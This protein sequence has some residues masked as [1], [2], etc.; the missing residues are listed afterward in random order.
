MGH[1]Y[2]FFIQL[3]GFFVTVLYLPI[4]IF[5]RGTMNK[6]DTIIPSL[7]STTT[8]FSTPEPAARLI[9]LIPDMEWDYIPA[10]R[11]I[12]ELAN[13]RGAAVLFLSLYTNTW[14]E[15]S[16]RRALVTMSAMLQDSGLSVE[17]CL[18][19]GTNWVELVRRKHQSSD[20]IIC[21]AGE[22]TGPLHQPLSQVLLSSLKIPVYI[23]PSPSLTKSRSKR[24]SQAVVWL[25]FIGIIVSFFI[26]Q[27]NIVQLPTGIF[28]NI[29]LLLSI[30][31]EYWLILFWNNQFG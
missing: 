13:T 27:I 18:E 24:H 4:M 30:I 19:H 10:L 20:T 29:L 22:R 16:L 12:W 28:Q 17:I 23:L 31:P 7:T 9:I 5:H 15:L 14:Q 6:T 1:F 26:M 2:L 8:S 25:G 3:G 11:R 21:F